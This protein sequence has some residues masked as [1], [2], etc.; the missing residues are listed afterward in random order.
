VGAVL[1]LGWPTAIVRS[2]IAFVVMLLLA[3]AIVLL[4]E[5]ADPTGL[6]FFEILK[7]IGLF[8]Y[9]FHHAG[10]HGEIARLEIPQTP[11]SPFAGS[12]EFS[13]TVSLALLLG[14]L[15]GLWLLYRGGRAV[16]RS[17]GGVA[18]ARAL[19]GA[20]VAI[21]YALLSLALSFVSGFS[22]DLPQSPFLPAGGPFEFG[23]SPIAAFLWPLALGLVAGTMGGLASAEQWLD[24]DGMGA[25]ARAVVRGGLV[26]TLYALVLAFVGYLVV[27]ALNPDLPLPFS[28]DFFQAV[29][30]EGL[31]GVNLLLVTVLAIP[32]IAIWVLVPAMGGSVGFDLAGFS[33]HFLSYANFPSA[34]GGEVP[35]APG[36]PGLP[37][38]DT[39][40]APYFLFLLVPL[41]AT[42]LGGW[43][44]ARRA[45]ARSKG[46][47][48]AVGALAGAVFAAALLLLI[49]LASL[50][51]RFSAGVAGFAQTG[52]GHVGPPSLLGF[53]L[54]LVWGASG[55]A[56]GGLLGGRRAAATV[57][58][59]LG[60]EGP[61]PIPSTG[62]TEAVPPV[63]PP[64]PS[65][66]PPEEQE[67]EDDRRKDQPEEPSS[68]P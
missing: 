33:Y 34:R 58:A 2:V 3:A 17:A 15:L 9:F 46:E 37:Q 39:A 42:L 1:A 32:N 20:K 6:S 16:A 19:H 11:A 60:F 55:G 28:P 5:A 29:A 43:W 63:P 45:P 47:G 66:V 24:P 59:P 22:V 49:V 27:V 31:G 44:A 7:V 61:A 57:S 35:V 67:D 51:L 25:R 50:G 54:A 12:A 18:W 56:L 53:L 26:M 62:D 40:P 48:A 38:L 8:F 10:I 13:F 52:R 21:P 64:P 14:T 4:A 41:V 68:P 30:S 23:P 65:D 36:I